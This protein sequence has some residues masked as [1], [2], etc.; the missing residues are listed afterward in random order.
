[1]Q[2]INWHVLLVGVAGLF[3]AGGPV[4]FVLTSFHISADQ[5]ASILKEASGVIGL[6]LAVGVVI[7]MA[8]SQTDQGKADTLAGLTPDARERVVGSMPVKD[9]VALIQTTHKVLNGQSPLSPK[10]PSP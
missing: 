3:V 10:D 1:M 6:L 4:A 2:K 9:Q 5:E 7:K 8:L